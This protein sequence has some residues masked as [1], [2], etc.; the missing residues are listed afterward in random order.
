MPGEHIDRAA[1]P[2]LAERDLE[3]G[4]PAEA[5]EEGNHPFD[6]RG[7]CFVEKSIEGLAAPPD[8]HVELSAEL[9]TNTLDASHRRGSELATLN[10]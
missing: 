2:I 4:L 1:L 3:P 6:D 8:P 5:G 7:V 10:V 9:L